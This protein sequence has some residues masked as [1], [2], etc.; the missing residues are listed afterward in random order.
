MT[1]I[2]EL[3]ERNKADRRALRKL[4]RQV[5]DPRPFLSFLEDLQKKKNMYR[6][7]YSTNIIRM[8]ERQRTQFDSISLTPY[9]SDLLITP[10]DKRYPEGV[11]K[12]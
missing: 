12:I 2:D 10:N 11:P 6:N 9:P 4:E 3:N 7:S 8:P 1:S 5:F